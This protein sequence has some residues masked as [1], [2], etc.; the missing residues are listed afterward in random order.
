MVLLA[1]EVPMVVGNTIAY[2]GSGHVSRAYARILAKPLARKL[3]E[4]TD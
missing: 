3:S 2:H 1:R 4:A